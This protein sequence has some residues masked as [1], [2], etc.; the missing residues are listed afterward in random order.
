MK[1]GIFYNH[2]SGSTLTYRVFKFKGQSIFK[3]KEY[4]NSLSDYIKILG[5][6]F[7]NYI[8][9]SANKMNMVADIFQIT[10]IYI[11]EDNVLILFP[12]L[13]NC[14]FKLIIGEEKVEETLLDIANNFYTK[15]NPN[16]W[17]KLKD[18]KAEEINKE[19]E[20]YKLSIIR[21]KH[22]WNNNLKKYDI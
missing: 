17:D 16:N 7:V 6:F 22:F 2:I 14:D 19:E 5:L 20:K 1:V 10:C 15:Y 11:Y 21:S 13:N 4:S 3:L 12:R 18:M 8:S 9:Y